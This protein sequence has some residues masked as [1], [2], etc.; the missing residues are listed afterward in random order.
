MAKQ[1]LV[2]T[3][4]GA[5][6]KSGTHPISVLYES[7]RI[8]AL[9]ARCAEN[10]WPFAILSSE[11]GLVMGDVAKPSYD[12][13]MTEDRIPI[14]LPQVT[15]AVEPYAAV[16]YFQAGAR[17]LYRR[18]LEEACLKAGVQ[19][20]AFGSGFMGGINDLQKIVSQAMTEN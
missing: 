1:V 18:L 11:Y 19:L 13:L 14:L 4:C 10:G 7:P 3:A 9:S 2:A 17:R 8:K 20:Y 5:K 16:V 15:T 12:R 6:K